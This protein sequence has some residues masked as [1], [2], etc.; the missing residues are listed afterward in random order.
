MI[1]GRAVAIW[2]IIVCLVVSLLVFPVRV[3]FTRE[4]LGSCQVLTRDSRFYIFATTFKSHWN[5]TLLQLVRSNLGG[6]LTPTPVTKDSRLHLIAGNGR[7]DLRLDTQA[8]DAAVG[9]AFVYNRRIYFT[10]G[11]ADS[12]SYPQILEITDTAIQ[13][14]PRDEAVNLMASFD[15][16]SDVTHAEGWTSS[17][18]LVSGGTREVPIAGTPYSVHVVASDSG[19]ELALKSGDGAIIYTLH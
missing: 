10:S 9:S 1:G 19:Y 7:G 3:S 2:L 8:I 5:P 12:A 6:A 13:A 16:F 4:L 18:G 17:G 14:L 11:V 15:K